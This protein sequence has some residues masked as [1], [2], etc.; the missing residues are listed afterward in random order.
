MSQENAKE[1]E[2]SP[3]VHD[4]NKATRWKGFPVKCYS[5]NKYLWSVYYV[6]GFMLHT[7]NTGESGTVLT[8]V[9][10]ASLLEPCIACFPKSGRTLTRLGRDKAKSGF[11][12]GYRSRELR[13]N[14][15]L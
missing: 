3:Q 11:S 1:I 13:F 2:Y 15:G 14:P 12:C 5:L 6:S 7:R 10:L 9:D 8:V 4:A